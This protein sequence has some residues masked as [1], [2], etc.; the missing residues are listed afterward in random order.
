MPH[1]AADVMY[2]SHA[3]EE[4][5][6]DT[7]SNTPRGHPVR[8]AEGSSAHHAAAHSAEAHK[9]ASASSATHTSSSDQHGLMPVQKSKESKWVEYTLLALFI[10]LIVVVIYALMRAKTSRE[11]I[12]DRLRELRADS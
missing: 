11:A 9:A 7:S 3:N 4:K 12:R 2:G 8:Y 5:H 10:A 6:G 1:R